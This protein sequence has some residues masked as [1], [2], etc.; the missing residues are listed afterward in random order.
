MKDY[1]TH[2]MLEETEAAQESTG[3]KYKK[4]KHR[5]KKKGGQRVLVR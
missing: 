5:G 3:K 2:E 4:E 1:D